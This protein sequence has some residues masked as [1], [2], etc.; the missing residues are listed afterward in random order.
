MNF[1]EY[2]FQGAAIN[3]PAL[4]DLLPNNYGYLLT[5]ING[6]IK[7][8]GGLH[9]R[10]ICDDPSWH[11]LLKIWTGDLALAKLYPAINEQDIPFGQDCVGDQFILREGVVYRLW[12]ETGEL[13]SL[14]CS[15]NDFLDNAGNDPVEY[16][17]LQPLL[18]YQSEGGSLQPGKLLSVYPPFCTKESANR[19]SLKAISALERISFLADFASQIGSGR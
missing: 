5:Q 16:L 15:F 14:G 6:F 1:S 12:A 9:I 18:Q 7:F 8:D 4:L 10:G 3:D 11:S 13:D 19:V 2:T 17:S